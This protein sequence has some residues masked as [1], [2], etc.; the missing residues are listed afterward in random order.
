MCWLW[1]RH[2]RECCEPI[3]NTHIERR[4]GEARS[5]ADVDDAA[6]V[7]P[8]E[9]QKGLGHADE[10]DAVDLVDPPQLGEGRQLDGDGV[11][12]AYVIVYMRV[13]RERVGGG[14]ENDPMCII[15]QFT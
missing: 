4:G 7:A 1:A 11:R 10:A 6:R 5:A 13:S 2:S 3:H 9:G 12:D 14:K 15:T 8:E